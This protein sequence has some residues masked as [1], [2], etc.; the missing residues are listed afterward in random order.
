[1]KFSYRPYQVQSTPSADEPTTIYRPVV[2]FRVHGP[3]GNAGLMGLLDT[4]ADA[5][6]L[7][8]F[9]VDQLGIVVDRTRKARFRGVGN[10][11]VA[12]SY[13]EVEIEIIGKRRSHRWTTLVGFLEGRSTAILGHTGFLERFKATFDSLSNEVRL[14]AHS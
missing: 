7:P 8:A 2:P 3:L 6:L 13:G 5:T 14:T 11:V 10:Q 9:L 12:V 1:M 4:G